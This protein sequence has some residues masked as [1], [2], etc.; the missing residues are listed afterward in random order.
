MIVRLIED[1]VAA[2]REEQS[3][4][5]KSAVLWV[6]VGWC[7]DSLASQTASAADLKGA[8]PVRCPTGTLNSNVIT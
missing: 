2:V 3:A 8:G 4:A 7:L 5:D 1:G 6:P